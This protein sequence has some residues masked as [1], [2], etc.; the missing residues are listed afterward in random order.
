MRIEEQIQVAISTNDIKKAKTLFKK[1][2]KDYI[3]INVYTI[4]NLATYYATPE[5][6][7]LV[8]DKMKFEL[9]DNILIT[10]LRNINSGYKKYFENYKTFINIALEKVPNY[11]IEEEIIIFCK[12][13]SKNKYDVMYKEEFFNVI[14]K[15]FFKGKINYKLINTFENRIKK[16]KIKLNLKDF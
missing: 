14:S 11:L 12:K 16:E 3:Q 7:E 2:E 5:M 1:I 4:L 6:I 15:E 8:L 10:T 13:E 9:T